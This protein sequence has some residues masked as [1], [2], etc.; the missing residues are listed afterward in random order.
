[1]NIVMTG[2]NEFV[3]LQGTA[4]GKPFSDEHLA[5]LLALGRKGIAD[6]LEIQRNAL[7]G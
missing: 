4:E 7:F 2:T 1:M 3:E 5:A 6:L